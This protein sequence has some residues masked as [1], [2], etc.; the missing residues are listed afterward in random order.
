MGK[1]GN[2]KDIL[3][4]LDALHRALQVVAAQKNVL[5]E[6]LAEYVFFPLSAVL[7]QLE[8]LPVQ[9]EE[10]TLECVL[11]LLSTAWRECV[12]PEL[13]IQLLIL[14]SFIAD[15]KGNRT[16]EELQTLTFRCLATL[17]SALSNDDEGRNALLK[18]TIMPHLGKTVSVI[19]DAITDAPSDTVRLSAISALQSFCDAVPDHEALAISF[20]PGIMSCMAKILTLKSANVSSKAISSSLHVLTNLLPRIFSDGITKGL[21]EKSDSTSTNTDR[22][23]NSVWLKATA[24]QVKMALANIVKLQQH[25]R[26]IVRQELA[27]LSMVLLRTCKDALSESVSMLLETLVTLADDNEPISRQLKGL[28]EDDQTFS[29]ILRSSL[30]YWIISLPRIMESADESKKQRRI[31][32]IRVTFSILNEL[33]VDMTVIDRDMA[34]N[35][36]DSVVN[37]TNDPK[38]THSIVDYGSDP[39][40]TDTTRFQ[41][42]KS[43]TFNNVLTVRKSQM[44]NIKEISRFIEQ[45]SLNESSLKIAQELV[46]SIY[47]ASRNIQLANFWVSLNILRNSF[48]STLSVDDLLDFGG[49]QA[50]SKEDL[51]EQLYDFSISILTDQSTTSDQDWRI[52]ALALETVALQAS[53]QKTGFRTELIEALYPVLHLIGSPV[54]QL[55]DHAIA[56]VNLLARECEY[57]DSGELIVANVDYLVNAVSLRLNTFNISPQA[58]QVLLMMV[59]LSGPSLLPYLDDLVDSMFAALESFHGYPKL[60]EL[61]FAVLKVI[62]EEGSKAPQLT[63]TAEEATTPHLKKP[64]IPLSSA[65][66]VTYVKKSRARHEQE[67]EEEIA[68][69]PVPQR[70]WKETNEPN[71]EDKDA[72]TSDNEDEQEVRRRETKDEEEKIPPTSRT[73]ALL[74]SVSRLTQHYLTSSSAELRTSLLSLLN[75]TFP[76]LAKH[77]NSFLPLIN[78]LW[79]VLL[80][81]LDDSEAY[82]V[83]GTLDVLNAMCVHAGDFMSGRID[84]AWLHIKSIHRLKTGKASKRVAGSVPIGSSGTMVSNIVHA[85]GRDMA[86]TTGQYHYIDAPSRIIWESLVRLLSTLVRYVAVSDNIFDDILDMLSPILAIQPDVREAMEARNPDAVW[87][88]LW[89]TKPQMADDTINKFFTRKQV[90]SN[91]YPERRFAEVV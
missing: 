50:Y 90:L 12:S 1:A 28:L 15:Q 43:T 46:D 9:A 14:F 44:D 67:K 78:T 63:I 22:R 80:P 39:Q 21:P 58:P 37:A 89:R 77:E 36:R 91:E 17:L 62:V 11:I 61:L 72:A 66:L 64:R 35:L 76:A 26:E 51:L 19:L 69:F 13:G 3:E 82:V 25:D 73:Y 5:N 10:Q 38:Q 45:L 42:S 24:P 47:G 65:E 79:P 53:R 34:V 48:E 71:E 8:K 56:T 57:K 49:S 31:H 83:A 40:S 86:T 6:K 84:E 59:K 68:P 30:H 54:P 20:L 4:K 75:T 55:R 88:A 33:A 27:R 18:T 2:A 85:P 81:R 16:S 52:H 60:V 29:D 74:L 7:K 87:L 32:Q 70:P 41:A 23:L